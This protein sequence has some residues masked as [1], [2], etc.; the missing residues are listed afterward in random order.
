MKKELAKAYEASQYEDKIYE[1][2]EKSGFFNPDNLN[3]SKDAKTYTIIL[4]PPNITDKLHI[5]HASTVAIQ[6]LLIRYH[7]LLGERT[8]WVP[9]T[10]HAAIATQNVVEKKILKEEGRTR[11][12][13]GK[14]EFLKRVWEF[15]GV[16]QSTILH[17][18]KKLGASLDWSR[19]AF[20]LDDQRKK[21]VAQMFVEMHTAGAIYRGERIVNWCPRCHSTL[22]DDE[23]DHVEQQAKL[24]TFKYSPDFPISISTTRP[25]TKLGDTAVA[26][27]PQDDRY[28]KYIGQEFKVNFV[29][30]DL[31]IKI[32]ADPNVEMDFGTGA[33]GV[34]PAHSL[35]D[36]Q[37]AVNNN[38]AIKKIINEDGILYNVPSPYAGLSALD[39]RDLVVAKLQD[40]N[41]LS[42]EEEISNNLSI[43]YRCSTAIEPLP[44]KQWFVAVDK[45]LERLKGLSLKQAAIQVAQSGQIKFWPERFTK[46]YLD[47]MISL[48][49]W[50]ISRQIWFGH[51]IPAWYKNDEVKISLDSP[52]PD[53]TQD[54]DTLDTWFSS[55]MWTFSTLGWPDNFKNNIKSGDL[56]N[57]HPTQVLETGYEIITLWVSR[58]IMMSLFA[59][60]EIPFENVYLHGMVLDK[61]GKKM[62]KSKG[63]GIDPIDVIDKYGTD[64][65]RLSLLCGT[66]PGNDLKLG[67]DKIAAQRNFANKL[68]NISRYILSNVDL[69]Y[70]KTN[71]WPRPRTQTDKF[72]IGRLKETIE[73]TNK[74][75]KNYEFSL[76]IEALNNFTW[77]DLANDY[78]E[79]SKKEKKKEKILAHMLKTILK[80]WHPMAPFVTEAIWQ[81]LEQPKLLMAE[82][83]PR[84][85]LFSKKYKKSIKW[86]ESVKIDIIGVRNIKNTTPKIEN[87]ILCPS[88]IEKN[89]Q[90]KKDRKELIKNFKT[91]LEN[92][93]FDS[94]E[95]N[96]NDKDWITMPVSGTAVAIFKL[97]NSGN[98]VASEIKGQ[99]EKRGSEL[100]KLISNL[101]DRLNNQEFAKKAPKIIIDKEKD[102]LRE[103][104]EELTN[105]EKE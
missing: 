56:Q 59:V 71:N 5:G 103:Y 14:E 85:R 100:K 102:K 87:F 36:W 83:W 19:L 97:K 44:S 41:L 2:W 7:R 30:V 4:P 32:I 46:K 66:T 69:K 3:L 50:C 48:H 51:Q 78:L 17:Q 84:Y 92:I 24:Y 93:G 68:W 61:N 75:L 98:S 21:A 39:A 23:V 1:L 60:N 42:Q 62:S 15:L 72:I 94:S 101:E 31:N 12:D 20:T 99:K 52:G 49:D 26:V 89:R 64:A 77:N 53:W 58:M 79:I 55:S 35:V 18:I 96:K 81:N 91:G 73:K 105:I 63:N 22:A 34:T 10:D 33:L 74:Y 43:C 27:N 13:L 57:F 67:D 104:Q 95:Y 88:P 38:L 45:P 80:L 37:M 6:D 9:G 47:W 86:F 11:H 8:L 16:T 76:A 40:Q 28:K 29:G 25:E 54:P 90:F 82:S 70:F 65:V